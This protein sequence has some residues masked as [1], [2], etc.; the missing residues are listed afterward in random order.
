VSVSFHCF[1]DN[2]TSKYIFYIFID[3]YSLKIEELELEDDSHY[4]CQVSAM[5]DEPFI[6]SD[7]AYI[8]VLSK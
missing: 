2:V 1:V 3:E 5:N 4:S 6:V 8:T 7:V